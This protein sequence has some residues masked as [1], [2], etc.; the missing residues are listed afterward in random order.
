MITGIPP[1]L[2]IAH[3]ILK[4]KR[5]AVLETATEGIELEAFAKPLAYPMYTPP[6]WENTIITNICVPG[7][8]AELE[9]RTQDVRYH[10]CQRRPQ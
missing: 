6:P 10:F 8:D 3:L 7:Y 1:A 2:Y 5:D 9:Q 4:F